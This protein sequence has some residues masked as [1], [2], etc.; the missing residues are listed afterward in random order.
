VPPGRYSGGECPEVT[1]GIVP[2]ADA[3][4]LFRPA[5]PSKV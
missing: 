5:P 1:P 3:E 4:R 2:V